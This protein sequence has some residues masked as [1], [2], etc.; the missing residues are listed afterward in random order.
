MSRNSS[1]FHGRAAPPPLRVTLGTGHPKFRSMWSAR[2]SS[3]RTRTAPSTVAGSTP[4]S[5]I[6]RG[7]SDSWCVMRRIVVALRSTSAREVII[8]LTYRPA[9]YSRHRRRNAVLVMPA[10][11]AS[12]TGA[13]S[14]MGPMRRVRAGARA[15]VT[16]PF[17]QTRR[18]LLAECGLAWGYDRGHRRS[19]SATSPSTTAD[20]RTRRSPTTTA[21]CC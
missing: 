16:V 11:G 5:W 18:A 20:G 1:S 3:T 19:T 4:Y 6:E 14:S 10:I 21:R 9:P 7:V 17:S 2:S 13:S 8:S 15:V 12:T